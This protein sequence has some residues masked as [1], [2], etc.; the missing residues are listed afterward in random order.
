MNRR[1]FPARPFA[2]RCVSPALAGLAL[3]LMFCFNAVVTVPAQE[4]PKELS[5]KERLEVFEDVWKTVK[6][7]YIDPKMRGLDWKAIREKHR[8]KIEAAETD[9]KFWRALDDMV[10]ELQDAHTNVLS[11]QVVARRRANK[12]A[13]AGIVLEALE[14][15]IVV[16]RV[17]EGSEAAKA[18]LTPGTEIRTIGGKPV[19]ELVKEVRERIGRSS[20]PQA[21]RVSI[22]RS[23]YGGPLDSILNLGVVRGD[24]TV[25]DVA[26]KR[27]AVPD[28]VTASARLLPSGL[29]YVQLSG[30]DDDNGKSDPSNLLRDAVKPYRKSPGLIL[31]LR[32][33]SGGLLRESLE[34]AGFFLGEGEPVGWMITRENP[35]VPLFSLTSRGYSGRVVI[36]VNGGTASAAELLAS[37]LHE[38]IKATVVGEASCGCVL[39]FSRYRKLKGGGELTVSGSAFVS[40]NRVLLEGMGVKPD[41]LVVPTIADLKSGRDAALEEA[42]RILLAPPAK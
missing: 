17:A 31:D 27:Y 41:R 30:L 4:A 19:N 33:N 18:G 36:L 32:D 29:A 26:L 24:G 42:E 1:T 39:G 13:T 15:K 38:G 10:G 21:T 16:V 2:A 3:V 8:P 9:A 25:V 34:V 6:D 12:A 35:S 23:L 20:S 7:T 11:P 40:R 14:G 5:P 28:Q 37:F 22:V